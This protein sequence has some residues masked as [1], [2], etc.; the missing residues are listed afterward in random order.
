MRSGLLI[1]ALIGASVLLPP[2][3]DAQ[4]IRSPY[5]YVEETHS[6]GVFAGYLST[7]RGDPAVGPQS[8]P[9]V[10]LRYNLRLSGPLSIEVNSSFA[11]THRDI[12]VYRTAEGEAAPTGETAPLNLF[13]IGG[14]LL[15]H[16][17]GD[18]TWNRI[19]PYVGLGGAIA[20][21]LARRTAF[22]AEIPEN[23]WF[24]FGPAFAVD[25]AAG[26]DV[27]LAER[28]SLRIQAW[29]RLIRLRVPEGLIGSQRADN[30]WTNNLG[31]SLG[32]AFHF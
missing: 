8:A 11:P 5:R 26:T 14:G 22:E 20:S 1:L 19:A 10:G 6:I 2:T 15:F 3:L 13:T 9:I 12:L 7:Q 23:Q 30:Q 4:Q 21:N 18:R 24:D 29:D 32:T 27:F 31:I 25:L 16:V 17:T 28:V